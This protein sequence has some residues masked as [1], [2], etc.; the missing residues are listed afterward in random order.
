MESWSIECI[1]YVSMGYIM[2]ILFYIWQSSVFSI[3]LFL[4]LLNSE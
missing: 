3:Y 4:F 1:E 2:S